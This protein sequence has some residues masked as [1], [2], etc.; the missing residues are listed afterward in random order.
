MARN[1]PVAISWSGGKDSCLAWLRAREAG[2]PVSTFVTMCSADG[3]SLSHAVSPA[4]LAAQVA[5]LGGD[6]IRVEVPAGGYAAAFDQT[7]AARYASGHRR[8]VFGDIDLAAHRVWITA[9]CER[10]G[11]EALFP[12]WGR[13]RS[14][15]ASEVIERGIRARLVCV[16]TD[17]LAADFCGRDY[18]AA[19]LADLPPAVC[20]CGENGEFHT[21]VTD[22]PGMKAPLRLRALARRSVPAL[23]PLSPAERVFQDFALAEPDPAE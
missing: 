10:A 4:V 11:I 20:P 7:L 22:A 3:A 6:L 1:S 8:M 14:A 23:P 16:R 13:A 18:D 2:W 9:A 19:L 15:V 5:A 12:L 17:A 21:L